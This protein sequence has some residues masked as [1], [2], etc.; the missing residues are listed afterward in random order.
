M[1]E[2]DRQVHV[3]A[4]PTDVARRLADSLWRGAITLHPRGAGTCVRIEAAVEPPALAAAIEAAA[5]DEVCALRLAV[6]AEQRRRPPSIPTHNPPH[7]MRRTTMTTIERTVTID[8]PAAEVWPALADFGGIATWNPNLKASHLTSD[9]GEGDG[10]TRECRLSPRG[11]IQERV[12][13]WRPGQGMTIEIYEFENVPA[14]RTGGARIDLEPMGDRTRVTMRL[15]YEVGLGALGAGMN[16][17]MMKRQFGTSVNRLLAGLKH[18]VET[19]EAVAT[20]RDL[21]SGAVSAVSAA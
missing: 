6:A 8:A 1:T 12:T 18:H 15:S 11:T 17:L 19:G 3:D 10:I 14:L 20:P 4:P 9:R 2:I 13:D 5:L 16:S 21:P 7:R